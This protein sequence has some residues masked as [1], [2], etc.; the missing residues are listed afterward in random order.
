M[1]LCPGSEFNT[2]SAFIDWTVLV[3]G[4]W[5]ELELGYHPPNGGQRPSKLRDGRRVSIAAA[6]LKAIGAKAGVL[7]WHLPVRRE[8]WIGLWIEFKHGKNDLSESQRRFATL[9]ARAGHQVHVVWTMEAG[10]VAAKA[11]LSHEP[12]P[13]NSLFPMYVRPRHVRP[14]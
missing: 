2:Q 5:P 13:P 8:P 1:R 11:Y 4:K 3:T 10:I 9:L 7:D 12:A 6:K 14:G